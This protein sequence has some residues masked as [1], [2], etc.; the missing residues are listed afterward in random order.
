[1]HHVQTTSD[2]L[3]EPMSKSRTHAQALCRLLVTPHA[4]RAAYSSSDSEDVAPTR[5]R[6]TNTMSDGSNRSYQGGLQ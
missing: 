3:N 5:S 1:M 2:L 4:L 6:S